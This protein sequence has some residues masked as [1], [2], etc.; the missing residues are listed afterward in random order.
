LP[1]DEAVEVGLQVVRA[2]LARPMSDP[3]VAPVRTV[4]EAVMKTTN[5]SWTKNLAAVLLSCCLAV[6]LLTPSAAL[7]RNRVADDSPDR[8]G[9]QIAGTSANSGLTRAAA[10]PTDRTTSPGG[11][12][13]AT[14][15]YQ[16]RSWSP[17]AR[18]MAWLFGG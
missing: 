6:A 4:K 11:R 13:S 17:L 16:S 1:V 9:N 10:D 3:A 8:I 14:S 7:A 12:A 2:L 18:M 5:Y 15:R